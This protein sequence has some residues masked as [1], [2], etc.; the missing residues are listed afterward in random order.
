MIVKLLDA[1]STVGLLAV[2]DRKGRSALL[3]A[4]HDATVWWMGRAALERLIAES[5]T[6]AHNLIAFLV[7]E[8][9]GQYDREAR[10]LRHLDDFFGSPNARMIPGPYCA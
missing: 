3:S 9:R 6:F 8:L 7:S 5:P 4:F 10:L 2:I 1:P